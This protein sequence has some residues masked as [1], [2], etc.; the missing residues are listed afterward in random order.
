MGSSPANQTKK[1]ESHSVVSNSLQPH[2]A[3][4]APL[5]MEFPQASGLPFPSGS[6]YPG[7]EP[8]SPALQADSLPS[9]PPGKPNQRTCAL[10]C[11]L[12]YPNCPSSQPPLFLSVLLVLNSKGANEVSSFRKRLSAQARSLN[13]GS[14]FV[15]G[16]TRKLLC[17]TA[18]L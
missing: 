14:G 12:E 3:H 7:I 15:G 17:M 5:S 13:Q 2:V 11:Y 10:T 1:S 4:Q 9:E 18:L 6:F 16:D 8:G